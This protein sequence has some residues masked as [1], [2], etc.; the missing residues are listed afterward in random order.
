MRWGCLFRWEAPR[1]CHSRD[2]G[3]LRVLRHVLLES[4]R[5]R[6]GLTGRFRGGLGA[7]LCLLNS[8]YCVA[9]EH[10]LVVCMGKRGG[11]SE[12]LPRT[13]DEEP[14][15]ERLQNDRSWVVCVA[16]PRYRLPH[17]VR[18]ASIGLFG[19]SLHREATRE[20]AA[21]LEGKVDSQVFLM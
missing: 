2:P 8:V 6:S 19:S 4:W 15:A 20:E 3:V 18:S 5:S 16:C 13:S 14:A 21:T 11:T 17:S 9:R 7:P 10:F 1:A 12:G